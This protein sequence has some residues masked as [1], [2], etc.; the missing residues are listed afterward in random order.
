MLAR[1][2]IF[3]RIRNGQNIFTYGI[4]IFSIDFGNPR[5]TV[6]VEFVPVDRMTG[7]TL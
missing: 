6:V 4:T 3:S 1:Q 2:R 7:R 5:V